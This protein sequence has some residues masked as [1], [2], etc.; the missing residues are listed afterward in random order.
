MPTQLVMCPPATSSRPSARK[1]WPE[2]KMFAPT[3]ATAVFTFVAGSHRVGLSA[4]SYPGHHSTLPVGSRC[5]WIAVYGHV[6]T[7]DHCPIVALF[8]APA[9]GASI[10]NPSR[11]E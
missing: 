7:G 4:T 8:C 6:I 1:E 11:I 3:L 10:K 9:D 5:A 2:Q